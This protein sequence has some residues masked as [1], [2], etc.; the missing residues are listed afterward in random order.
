MSKPGGE[1][2]DGEGRR[3]VRILIANPPWQP[4]NGRGLRVGADPARVVPDDT[5]WLPWPADLAFLTGYLRTHEIVVSLVDSIALGE[6]PGSYMDRLA[7]LEL[8]YVVLALSAA[9][10]ADDLPLLRQTAARQPTIALWPGLPQGAGRLLR[11]PGV[12]AVVCGEAERGLLAALELGESRIYDEEALADL[13]ELPEP[14]RD[15]TLHLYRYPWAPEPEAPVLALQTARDGGRLRP[16]S[17]IA[18]EL[19]A[20]LRNHPRLQQAVVLDPGLNHSPDRLAELAAELAAHGLAWAGR[21]D[22]RGPWPDAIGEAAAWQVRIE[23]VPDSDL[24]ARLVE[25]ARA[26]KVS[27]E[28]A[29]GL[30]RVAIAELADDLASPAVDWLPEVSARTLGEQLAEAAFSHPPRPRRI[31]VVGQHV[32]AYMPPWLVHGAKEAGHPAEAVDLFA[33]PTAIEVL[34]ATAPE[35]LILFDRGIGVPV[36]LLSKMPGRTVLYYPDNLP[37]ERG[38]SPFTRGR[39]AEFLPFAVRCDDVILHD[40]HALEWLRSEGHHNVRGSVMLPIDPHRHRDLGLERTI[41]LLFMGTLSE[42]RAHWLQ[43]LEAAGVT[44]TVRE[45]WGDAYIRLLNQAKMVLNL[46]YTPYPNTE[47]RIIEA[48]ACGACVVT[49]PTTEPPLLRNGQHLVTIS[50]ETAADTI[51]HY[52]EHDGDRQPLVEAGRAYVL[53]HFTARRCIEQI[54]ALLPETT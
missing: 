19:Q 8:D 13:A 33:D 40:H 39:Y 54:L 47:L 11:L 21:L 31:L 30:D 43:R 9:S 1:R 36:E 51:R 14:Y 46:H 5:H 12:E 3:P 10:L 4:T 44:V 52:L 17:A 49:E 20:V 15:Y 35:D 18:E 32:P 7:D 42:H 22:P 29:V 23:T 26:T 53:E 28:P 37:S 34:L 38:E 6:S 2:A 24:K 45:A 41:D 50:A 16:L 25:L 48:L 27:L